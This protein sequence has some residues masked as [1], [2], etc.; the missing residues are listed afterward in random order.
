MGENVGLCRIHEF[1]TGHIG[2]MIMA[3]VGFHG[4]WRAQRE[5]VSEEQGS[6]TRTFEEPPFGKYSTLAEEHVF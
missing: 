1:E 6:P 3:E 5:G 2:L 4:H